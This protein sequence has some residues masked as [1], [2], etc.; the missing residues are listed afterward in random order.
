[1]TFKGHNKKI[2]NKAVQQK[3]ITI[4]CSKLIIHVINNIIR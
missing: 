2:T 3:D 1:M 4:K